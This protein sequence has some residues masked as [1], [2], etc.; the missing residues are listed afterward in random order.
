M[1]C[2]A[3]SRH[4][5]FIRSAED[6]LLAHTTK[7]PAC[8]YSSAHNCNTHSSCAASSCVWT[9]FWCR[10]A[11][12]CCVPAGFNLGRLASFDVA[13]TVRGDPRLAQLLLQVSLLLYPKVGLAN[14]STTHGHLAGRKPARLICCPGVPGNHFVTHRMPPGNALVEVFHSWRCCAALW[15]HLLVSTPAVIRYM[16]WGYT[17]RTVYCLYCFCTTVCCLYCL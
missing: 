3:T 1:L 15:L 7:R 12:P 2:C 13:C 4:L 16:Y 5:P 8:T 10:M 14:E 9:C 6:G 11:A 17:G